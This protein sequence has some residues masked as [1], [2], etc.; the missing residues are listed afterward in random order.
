MGSIN[1]R[2]AEQLGW[3]LLGKQLGRG[4]QGDVE[5]VER[6][7]EPGGKRYALKC[8]GERGGPKALERFRTELEALTRINHP[9]IV[10][11][12]EYA[13]E[14]DTPQYYVMDYVEG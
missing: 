12:V 4:G 10:K 14:S 3:K 5:L 2:S 6:L 1:S 13:K 7:S 9:G 8:L 11:V